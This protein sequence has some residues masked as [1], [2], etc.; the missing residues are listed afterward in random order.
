MLDNGLSLLSPVLSETPFD[1]NLLDFVDGIGNHP[2]KLAIKNLAA[3][4]ATWQIFMTH[5]RTERQMVKKIIC[6]RKC[7]TDRGL[8]YVGAATDLPQPP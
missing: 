2:F 7:S 8:Y 3:S 5:S 4:E 1:M 6:L